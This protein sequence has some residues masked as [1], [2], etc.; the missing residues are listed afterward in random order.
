MARRKNVKRIDPRYFLNET[1]L[2]EGDEV[3]PE[4][5]IQVADELEGDPEVEKAIQAALQDPEIMAAVAQVVGA[6]SP[7]LEEGR[8]AADIRG[9]SREDI[10]SAMSTSDRQARV[11]Q[12]QQ[13]RDQRDATWDRAKAGLDKQ[14]SGEKLGNVPVALGGLATIPLSVAAAGAALAAA[15]PAGIAGAALIS[16]GGAPVFAGLALSALGMAGLTLL[17]KRRAEEMKKTGREEYRDEM[18]NL[19]AMD[20]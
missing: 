17:L 1:V 9:G 20:A 16:I 13:R 14:R 2:R 6:D 11:T 5:V 8:S 19:D 12:Q 7:E 4:E 15:E 10:E 3:S 18:A